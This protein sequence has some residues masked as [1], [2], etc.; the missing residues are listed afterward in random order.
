MFAS[1]TATER[2]R[3][4]ASFYGRE[5]SLY[6]RDNTPKSIDMVLICCLLSAVCYLLSAV[7]RLPSAPDLFLRA[8]VQSLR[9][10]HH[11]QERRSVTSTLYLLCVSRG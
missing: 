1:G 6:A 11:S 8:G 5:Y 10:G 4:L 9:E 2:L 3:I 7:C